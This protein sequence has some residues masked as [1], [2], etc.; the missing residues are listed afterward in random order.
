[1]GKCL[2]ACPKID[3]GTLSNSIVYVCS[4]IDGETFGFIINKKADDTIMGSI[5]LQTSINN[6]KVIDLYKGGKKDNTKAFIIHT[7]DYKDETSINVDDDICVSSSIDVIRDIINSTG[8]RK[9]LI[10]LGYMTW[11]TQI[12]EKEIKKN[13]WWIIEPTEKLLF[14]DDSEKKWGKVMTEVL[15]IDLDRFYFKEGSA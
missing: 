10:V 11:N 3:M 15:G 7:S 2:I 9:Y 13:D 14:S 8:P 4:Q 5:A 12:L 6:E 1:M